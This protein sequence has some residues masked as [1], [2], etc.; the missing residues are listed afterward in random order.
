MRASF[1]SGETLRQ[2]LPV[3]YPPMDQRLRHVEGWSLV[4]TQVADPFLRGWG[5]AGFH[6]YW[7]ITEIFSF[8]LVLGSNGVLG[9]GKSLY[10]YGDAVEL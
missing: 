4:L 1:L 9:L 7:S 8:D 6:L 3:P 5:S 2:L 10:S